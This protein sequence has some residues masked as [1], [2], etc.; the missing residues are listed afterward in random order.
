MTKE[1]K[2]TMRLTRRFGK[3]NG[4]HMRYLIK[5]ERQEEMRRLLGQDEANCKKGEA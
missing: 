3:F 4:R 5:M 1:P 2:N